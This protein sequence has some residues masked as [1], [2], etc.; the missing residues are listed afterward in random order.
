MENIEIGQKLVY[1]N[2]HRQ[3]YITVKEFKTLKTDKW[4]KITFINMRY[5]IDW[6][7]L[8]EPTQEEL[9]TCDFNN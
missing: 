7:S 2:G 9:D 5:T 6:S 8:R 3:E 1:D 4:K